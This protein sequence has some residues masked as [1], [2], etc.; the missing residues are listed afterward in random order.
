MRS[1]PSRN[2]QLLN[3]FRSFS[4]SGFDKNRATAQVIKDQLNNESSLDESVEIAQNI[5]KQSSIKSLRDLVQKRD[6]DSK[7]QEALKTIEK[8]K[9]LY[10]KKNLLLH[11]V[12][13]KPMK[14]PVKV[15]VTGA[16]GA[17]GYALL[18]RIASGEMLGPDQPV[19]L[20]LLEL[21]QA[22]K[23]LEGVTME[24][25]DC[26]F[27]L[28]SG[29]TATEKV[30]QAFD[31]IEYA[32]LV[33]A[34]PRSK[35]MERGD[36]LKAN[37]QIFSV[38]GKALSDFASKNVKVLVVGNPANT[39]A[40][41]A[42]ANAPKLDPK[43][44]SA[45]TKLDHNRGLAQLS[46]K[47]KQPVT[48]IK[49]FCIWG[50][51]SSTQYPDISHTQIGEKWAKELVDQKWVQDTFIPVV[52]QRGA[53]IINARGASSAA[54]AASAAIDHMREWASSTNGEWTS[55]A[56]CSEGE[57]GITK[58]LYFSY[59]IV[60]DEGKYTIVQNVPVDKFSAERIETSH[61]ELLSERDA[62]KDYLKS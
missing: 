7:L 21:P 35:G 28:L 19:H 39:N 48:A 26:A 50:N 14:P 17:I 56:V 10:M 42:A 41:I 61:K 38:Q 54:S 59:P 29:I 6:S 57:Y 49:K 23:S 53:A 9:A 58:G 46:E 27:P 62:V 45:M 15:A 5:I 18:F 60:C 1:L 22:M 36:L 51:H 20:C 16:S 2:P 40:F 44:F 3:L 37:G 25:N 31:G 24:L 8:N 52:Q 43:C 55:M 30:E 12:A 33:G 11:Y 4:T 32:L 13:D 34:R 47:T